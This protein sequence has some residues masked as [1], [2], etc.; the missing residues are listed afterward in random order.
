MTEE[1][2]IAAVLVSPGF[3]EDLSTWR[4][5]ISR[6]GRLRQEVSYATA[7]NLYRREVRHESARVSPADL[8]EILALAERIGFQGFRDSY[9]HETMVV[10]DLPTLSISVRSGASI[11]TVQAYGPDDIACMEGNRDMAGWK[12][13]GFPGAQFEY[14]DNILQYGQPYQGG[15]VSLAQYQGQYAQ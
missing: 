14:R 9:T 10:T 6:D 12:L 7:A 1:N 3:C 15:Y 8:A 4:L 2:V 11:K 13:I 5:T